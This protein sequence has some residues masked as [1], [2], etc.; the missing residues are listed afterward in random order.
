M[1]KGPAR[2]GLRKGRDT[3]FRFGYPPFRHGADDVALRREFV[4]RGL[5]AHDRLVF[6]LLKHQPAPV[7]SAGKREGER[8]EGQVKST[9]IR[10]GR[11]P[12]T[13][14]S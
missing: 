12:R 13:G 5:Q 8:Y 11:G 4:V 14:V 10:R 1:E 2:H 3:G 7:I 6:L 9:M